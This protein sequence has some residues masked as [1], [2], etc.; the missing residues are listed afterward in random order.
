MDVGPIEPALSASRDLKITLVVPITTQGFRTI[1]E[2]T[3]YLPPGVQCELRQITTGPASIECDYDDILAAPDVVR[4]ALEAEQNGADAVIVDCMA[5]PGV[6]AARELLTIPVLGP[7]QTSM[8]VASM[9][10]HRFGYLTILRNLVPSTERRVAMFGLTTKLAGVS[11][12][13]VPVL[14]LETDRQFTLDAMKAASIG[15]IEHK[16]AHA[17]V[18]GCTGLLWAAPL[19]E[20]SLRESGYDGIPVVNPIPTTLNVAAALVRMNLRHSGLTYPS[21]PAKSPWLAKQADESIV[22]TRL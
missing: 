1:S 14:E 22:Q 10:A 17:I 12:I 5:D 6:E 4:V 18:L 16:G 21:P 3:P 13:D 8:H 19:L 2:F 11:S 7:A 20:A 15:L 9:L